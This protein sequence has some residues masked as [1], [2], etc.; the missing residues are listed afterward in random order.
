M[1]SRV[2]RGQSWVAT[3]LCPRATHSSHDAISGLHEGEVDPIETLIFA[4]ITAL[5]V[6]EVR[7]ALHFLPVDSYLAGFALLLAFYFVTGLIHSHL[8]RHLTATLAVEY[9]MIAAAGVV[10]VVWARN[11]GIA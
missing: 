11:A 2:A 4:V 3:Q 10:L 5:A 8:V 9:S 6:A 1:I 7:W